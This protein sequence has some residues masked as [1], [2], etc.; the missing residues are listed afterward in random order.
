MIDNPENHIVAALVS[1][2]RAKLEEPITSR[3]LQKSAPVPAM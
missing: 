1:G 3:K 2:G